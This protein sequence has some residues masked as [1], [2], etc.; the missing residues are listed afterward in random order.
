MKRSS[1]NAP[2]GQLLRKPPRVPWTFR[3][4]PE[5]GPERDSHDARYQGCSPVHSVNGKR[6]DQDTSQYYEY[7]PGRIEGSTFPAPPPTKTSLDVG[8]GPTIRAGEQAHE[9]SRY[10]DSRNRVRQYTAG[11]A[12]RKNEQHCRQEHVQS[13]P[14]ARAQSDSVATTLTVHDVPSPWRTQR[15]NTR[16]D[17][18]ARPTPYTAEY[19]GRNT[20]MKQAELSRLARGLPSGRGGS[21]IY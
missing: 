4:F 14:E 15:P 19:A 3:R 8:R 2:T 13:D 21:P 16:L 7:P 20:A 6:S 12:R 17:Y 9:Q 18:R 5:N 11:N 10:C 1:P